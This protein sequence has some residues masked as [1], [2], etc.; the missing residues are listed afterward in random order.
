MRRCLT[1]IK[2]LM[3]NPHIICST[4]KTVSRS[5]KNTQTQTILSYKKI[6]KIPKMNLQKTSKNNKTHPKMCQKVHLR[7][8]IK[9]KSLELEMKM[10]AK[11]SHRTVATRETKGQYLRVRSSSVQ[12][13]TSRSHITY[14]LR[15]CG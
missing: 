9:E 5:N 8:K 6:N 13:T 7:H 11:T 12:P 1:S 3:P 4:S 2:L 14:I 15:R 10:F